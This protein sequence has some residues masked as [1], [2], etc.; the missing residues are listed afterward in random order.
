MYLPGTGIASQK[1][2]SCQQ[3]LAGICNM[4]L[5]AVYGMF[6]L[7]VEVCF[8]NAGKGKIL[9]LI[10]SVRLCLFIAEPRQLI[11]RDI[12]DQWFFY[13]AA[14]GGGGSVCVHA[15]DHMGVNMLLFF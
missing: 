7:N 2:W 4:G 11:L 13:I 8:L 5:E 12:N 14:A 15:H 10:L 1:S 9:F 6:I 3:N